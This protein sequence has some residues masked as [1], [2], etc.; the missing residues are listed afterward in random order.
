[1]KGQGFE[2]DHLMGTQTYTVIQ[3]GF[4]EKVT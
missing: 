2:T 3:E 4:L 1:M